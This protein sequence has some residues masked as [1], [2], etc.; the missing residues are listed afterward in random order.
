MKILLSRTD[1]IGDVVL[2]LPMVA[3]L[4]NALPDAAIYFLIRAYTKPIVARVANVAGLITL[5]TLSAYPPP[6]R[7]AWLSKF[8]A[9]IHVFP[10]KQIAQWARQAG[11]KYRVGVNRRI[12]HWWHCNVQVAMSRVK[13]D[14]H[15]AQLNCQLGYGLL[16]KLNIANNIFV[17][18]DL[19]IAADN[20]Q[21]LPATVQLP[22]SLVLFL[23]A[24]RL[25]VYI[26]HPKS[27]GSGSEWP[28]KRFAS[29]CEQATKIAFM[30][31]GKSNE[32]HQVK[33]VVDN[34]CQQFP[35]RIY[36]AMGSMSLAQL[37]LAIQQVDGV[38]A[39]STGPL[40]IAGACNTKTFGLFAARRPI[41]PGRWRPLGRA[42]IV[43]NSHGDD[44]QAISASQVVTVIYN[45]TSQASN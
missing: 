26:I 36:N 40:H 3:Y 34:L 43:I 6:Q 44:L 19:T 12:F 4:H 30:F 22:K 10:N 1:A 9:I 35:Q 23:Q 37:H 25:P 39:A 20:I 31:T 21:W 29:V 17:P 11:I 42:S 15:E 16:Q 5:E 32:Y 2:T 13:S 28:I 24:T 38:L 14:L 45:N 41:H 7:S 33:G 8:D 18:P 27:A